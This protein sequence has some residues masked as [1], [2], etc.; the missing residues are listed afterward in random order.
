[1][2]RNNS[3]SRECESLRRGERLQGPAADIRNLFMCIVQLDELTEIVWR[4]GGI[5]VVWRIIQH[6]GDCHKICGM[7]C[8]CAKHQTNP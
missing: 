8:Q 2:R 4:Y 1:M 5:F 7:T 6:F 3:V